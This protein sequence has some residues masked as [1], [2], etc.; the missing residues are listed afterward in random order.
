MT[1]G[2]IATLDGLR[3]IAVMGILL[4]NVNAFA[5]PF[6]AYD[7]PAAYGS[8][9]PADVALWA[10]EFV[11][12]DGKMRAIFSALFGASL[13]LVTDRA[14]AAGRSAVRTHYARMAT[15]LLFGLLHACLVWEGDILTLY[16]LVGMVAFSARRLAVE[17]LLVLAAMLLAFQTA[18]LGVHYQALA[19][20]GEAAARPNP[21]AADVAAWRA[22]I[23]DI[24][25]VRPAVLAQDLALH[26]GP[27]APLARSMTAERGG[28]LVA[29]FL[30]AGSETL[31]LM[32][33]GM[34]G[35]RSGFLSGDWS[36]DAYRRVARIAYAIG[37]PAMAALSVL[38]IA[39]DFP[40]LLVAAIT[41]LV[42]LPFRWLLG[43][44]HGAVLILWLRHGLSPLHR[45]L[46]AAGR[47]AFTN[48]LGTSLLM[49]AVF[50]GWGLGLYG[51]VE[52]WLLLPFVFATWAIM[53]GWSKP[54]LERFA[55]GPL[56]WLWR[57]LARAAIPPLRVK[58]IE[59]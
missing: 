8:L 49:T 58:T 56:E 38:L 3:G 54:W 46:A 43:V 48:Y 1:G 36:A 19:A 16:A 26:R 2:R 41:E 12:V 27:W 22:L 11:F 17:R 28:S 24:G 5:M 20:L 52:R 44:A 55:F 47:C 45:R 39:R 31:G 13:L 29:E 51:R 57:A 42:A 23:D 33:L 40:P 4:M 25:R 21:A 18:I 7:N 37:L 35:L 34:A 53:L 50:D 10:V 6:A 14:E 15:L 59:S 32:L 9:R 30:F